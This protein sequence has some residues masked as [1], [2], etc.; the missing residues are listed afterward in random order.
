MCLIMGPREIFGT[1]FS[2]LFVIL[3]MF[4]IKL[5]FVDLIAPLWVGIVCSVLL[6]GASVW[7]CIKLGKWVWSKIKRR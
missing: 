3:S 2:V 4:L 7:I 5:F 1:I 6:G